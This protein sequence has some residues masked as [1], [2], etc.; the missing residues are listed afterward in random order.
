MGNQ[1]LII[2]PSLHNIHTNTTQ[3]AFVCYTHDSSIQKRD[4][5]IQC[6]VRFGVGSYIIESVCI[7]VWRSHV[8][9]SQ[10]RRCGEGYFSSGYVDNWGPGSTQRFAVRKWWSGR[11]CLNT[12][13]FIEYVV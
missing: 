8:N 9:F 4:I 2:N 13:Y 3:N 12:F 5:T 7:F 10:T 11:V 1:K 6:D